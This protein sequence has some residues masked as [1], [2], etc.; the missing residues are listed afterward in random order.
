MESELT[1]T[2]HAVAAKRFLALGDSYT[3]GES[4]LESE[5]WPNQLVS[6]LRAEQIDIELAGIV[7]R[8]GWTSSE[9]IAEV[10]ATELVR[11]F[12][13]VSLLIGVNNQYRGL[14]EEQFLKELDH[15]LQMAIEFVDGH[16]SR[17]IVLSI[18]DWGVTPFAV[19]RDRIA[20]SEQIDRFNHVKKEQTMRHGC[21]FIDVSQVSR[22]AAQDTSLLAND[23]LH[24]SRKLYA[25]WC[26]QVLPAARLALV[27]Q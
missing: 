21:Q 16:S 12:D 27:N 2:G 7:A 18:P 1:T 8:T 19:D 6:R 22:K 10:N 13:L 14:C 4:V 26:E 9:L 24:P 5:R 15:L 25:A 11:P 20:I 17:V 23:G 3:I